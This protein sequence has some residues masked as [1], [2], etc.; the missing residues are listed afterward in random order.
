[1]LFG[2]GCLN[3]FGNSRRRIETALGR[4]L[5][6]RRA[7]LD[8]VLV[9]IFFAKRLLTIL[10]RGMHSESAGWQRKLAL[11]I[12]DYFPLGVVSPLFTMLMS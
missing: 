3:S 1:M 9:A 10:V 8:R 7:V 5:F 2:C 12:S 4:R 11:L 6:V